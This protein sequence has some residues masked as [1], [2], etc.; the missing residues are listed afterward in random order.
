M[1]KHI[2]VYGCTLVVISL[3]ILACGF[4]LNL[5]PEP[6]APTSTPRLEVTE[7]PAPQVIVLIS[8]PFEETSE[9]PPYRITAQIPSL[10]SRQGSEESRVLLF[11]QLV[12]G[13]VRGDIDSFRTSFQQNASNPLVVMGS[14]YD[15][16]YA[17]LSPAGDV[18]SLKFD[19]NFYSDGAAHPGSY[20]LTF[21]YDLAAGQQLSLEQLFLPGSD[22][23]E[24]MA[25]YC[26]E[27]L[28]LRDIAYSEAGADPILEN[29]RN[30]N[31]TADGLLI[32]FDPY[33]VAAYAAGPQTVLV[34]YGELQLVIDPHSPLAGFVE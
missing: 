17:L 11:N 12:D 8:I 10:Q 6:P 32:S 30:W 33:Q 21:N 13:L 27:Q 28:N 7:Q 23:L 1:N 31:I 29:Y 4:T 15:L 20:S 26:K 34:P 22:Y 24:R 5:T 3:A 25:A 18:M 2:F 16:Q 14:T 19:I 9:T